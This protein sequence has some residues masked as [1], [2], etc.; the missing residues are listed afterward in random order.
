[1]LKRIVGRLVLEVCEG[2]MR[3]VSLEPRRLAYGFEVGRP[4]VGA[5]ATV[6]EDASV[7]DRVHP[8]VRECPPQTGER[9]VV[10]VPVGRDQL[11]CAP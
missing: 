5:L 11:S 6:V 2:L 4:T 3:E 10:G 9:R 7:E 8:E 1:M